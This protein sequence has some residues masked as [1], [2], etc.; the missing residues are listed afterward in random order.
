MRTIQIAV[1]DRGFVA[2][3]SKIL[4][5]SGAAEFVCVDVPDVE[6]GGVLVLDVDALGRIPTPL[7]HP[8]RVVLLAP[9]DQGELTRAFEAG[10]KSVVSNRDALDTVLLAILAVDLG[11][12]RSAAASSG[13]SP[14]AGREAG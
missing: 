9:E 3:L 1:A 12:S 2:N 4:E 10:I 5:Q 13:R 11:V 8:E 14:G 6:R 7:A